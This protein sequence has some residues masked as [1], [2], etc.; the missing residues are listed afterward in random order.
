V[1]ITLP[2]TPKHKPPLRN[3]ERQA[4]RLRRPVRP[5]EWV[6]KNFILGKGHARPGPVKLD[7]WQ[8]EPV[9]SIQD[10][11]VTILDMPVQVGKSM[12]GE[13]HLGWIIDNMPMNVMVCFA[14]SQTVKDVFDERLRPMIEDIPALSRYWNGDPEELTLKKI[15]LAHMI[16]RIASAEVKSDIATFSAGYI[17]GDEIAKY[18]EK[19]FDQIR[20][21]FGRQEAYRRRGTIRATMLSSPDREGDALHTLMYQ[22]GVTNLELFHRCPLCGKYQILTD[23]QV[24]EIPT[25]SGEFDHNP[26]RIRRTDAARYECIHCHKEIRE[27]DRVE[28]AKS[29]LWA[30][31][32][33]SIMMDGTVTGK[34]GFVWTSYNCNRFVDISFTFSECLAR[35]FAA[36]QSPNP[37]SLKTYQNEDM[38]RYSKIE[39]RTYSTNWLMAKRG[40]GV[41]DKQY[42]QYGETAGYPV[43][44]IVLTAGVDTQDAGFFFVVRAWGENMETWLVLEGFIE[45]PMSDE[46]YKNKDEIVAL[47]NQELVTKLPVRQDGAR[48][49][50]SCAFWDR[51]GHRHKDVDYIAQHIPWVHAYVGTV[52]HRA[53]LIERSKNG[54]YFL[55]HT[56]RLSKTIE[57]YS[58][59][60]LWHLPEDISE[61]YCN[62]FL[63]QY[64]QEKIDRHGNRK[65]EYVHGGND[66]KRDCENLN[67]AAMVYLQLEQRM[68]DPAEMG[69]IREAHIPK[70]ANKPTD[71][72]EGAE[73][74]TRGRVIHQRKNYMNRYAK[75]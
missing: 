12:I 26:D 17:Q 66:H 6:E 15:T 60:D 58:E 71:E 3:S 13:C 74:A 7:T 65:E 2:K 51:G 46:K 52:N 11:P 14:K 53:P 16:I 63:K 45:C 61:D 41:K 40:T 75:Y 21:L 20:A 33:E 64:W 56:E 18:P 54:T 55:G 62:Q 49:P 72:I 44:S 32:Y 4:F 50:I 31:S 27:T 34:E 69:K 22:R 8:I 43:G 23:E 73:S 24:K 35:F 47:I 67:A 70:V 19:D 28:M 5:S 42:R 1:G 29:V 37:V 68:F 59:S 25:E 38:G 39:S 30:P 10:H 36:R 48:L 9:N 57:G